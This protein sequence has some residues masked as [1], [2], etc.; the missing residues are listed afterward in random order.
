MKQ[1]EE[2]EKVKM[3]LPQ[4]RRLGGSEADAVEKDG[5]GEVNGNRLMIEPDAEDA[6]KEGDVERGEGEVNKKVLLEDDENTKAEE[7]AVKKEGEEAENENWL[8]QDDVD[9]RGLAHRP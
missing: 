6:G 1:H 7:E 5:E 3:S 2:Q 8:V 4:L 9:G